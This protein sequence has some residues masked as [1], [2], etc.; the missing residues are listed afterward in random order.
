MIKLREKKARCE[1]RLASSSTLW[2]WNLLASLCAATFQS[3]VQPFQTWRGSHEAVC[4]G[5][6]GC[7]TNPSFFPHGCRVFLHQEGWGS[8][9]MRSVK[10]KYPMPRIDTAF[11]PLQKA[12]FFMKL[13]RIHQGD[14]WNR[15]F[16]TPLGHFKYLL[17]PFGLTN[18]PLSFRHSWMTSCGTCW[19]CSCL[20]TLMISSSFLRP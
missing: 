20:C 17:M 12:Q 9:T 14:E 2:L 15:L 5:L 4:S 1:P 10:N 18:I 16:N 19:I 6:T 3:P 8:L 11:S 13:I 7:W